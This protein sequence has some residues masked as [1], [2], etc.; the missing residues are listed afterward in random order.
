MEDTVPLSQKNFIE[1][2][3]NNIKE[4]WNDWKWQIKN[5]ITTKQQLETKNVKIEDRNAPVLIS[6]NILTKLNSP[7]V[8]VS[9]TGSSGDI[10]FS[11][12]VNVDL[13]GNFSTKLNVSTAQ[14]AG[15]W[16]SHD[17]HR[18]GQN[19]SGYANNRYIQFCRSPQHDNNRQH[20]GATQSY[21]KRHPQNHHHHDS[22]IQRC[23]SGHEHA[24]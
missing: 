9:V 6:G 18:S 21:R 3:F 10:I 24:G 22:Q 2:Y 13:T 17:N 8:K 1:K 4:E 15:T 11:K 20:R 7:F 19:R 5:S 23:I 14:T 12:P 16:K